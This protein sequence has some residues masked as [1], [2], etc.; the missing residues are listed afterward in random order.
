MI[1][2]INVIV[3]SMSFLMMI[4]FMND[5]PTIVSHKLCLYRMPFLLSRIVHFPFFFIGRSFWNLLF[6][7]ICESKKAY[8][9]VFFNFLWS[10]KPFSYW[11]H[12]LWN[13]QALSHQAFNLLTIST[14]DATLIQIK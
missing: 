7:R 5:K 14:A 3:M 6:S 13:W 2:F 8:R 12:L 9:K 10:F 11:I 1:L 4:C